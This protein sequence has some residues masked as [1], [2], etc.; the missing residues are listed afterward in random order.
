MFPYCIS[1][2]FAGPLGTG[3]RGWCRTA[4]VDGDGFGDWGFC[5]DACVVAGMYGH[6][7]SYATLRY[8]ELRTVP[9]GT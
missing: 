5:G 1:R 7:P 6:S 8:V 4:D 3:P 9:C 2:G